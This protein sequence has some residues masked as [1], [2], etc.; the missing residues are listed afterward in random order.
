MR[1][2][3][4]GR[5]VDGSLVD[6]TVSG[7]R[8][9]AVDPAGST[10]GPDDVDLD[11]R[12]LLPALGEPHAHLDK[13]FTADLLPNPRGDLD[14]AVEAILTAWPAISVEDIVGRAERAVRRLVASGT[15][16]IRSHADVT[17]EGE[18]KSV[19]AL[20]EV[21]RRTAHLCH[22][23]VV[24]LTMPLSGLEGGNGR[25]RLSE[26][27]AGGADV[28]G[29]CPHL[30]EE[31][32]A[33]IDAALA[34]AAE[35]GTAADLHFDEVLDASVQHLPDLARQVERRG[36]GGRVTASHCVSH[37][38]LSADRQ[39]HIGRMLADAGV[40]VVTNPRTNL[41][42]QGRG[43]E[44]GP[45]RGLAGVRAL[46]DTG[47]VVAAGADNVQDPFYLIGRSDP[48]ETA[49][50]CVAAAHLTVDE[51]WRLVGDGVRAV[52]GLEPVA[53]AA[54]SPADV[55]AVRAG[56]VREAI[57]D[58]PPD[59]LVFRAGELVAHTRVDAWTA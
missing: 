7:G 12:L 29:A 31:P 43:V 34:A 6:I 21:K 28:V 30:D 40:A 36:L 18:Q 56:S 49:S 37:G 59:R 26:A 24:A 13:A 8:V 42:L 2:L 11:G 52:L 22:L 44:Q 3:R 14:G 38:L 53:V 45:P 15:T 17:P 32:L 51:A 9:V 25:R 47:V 48:L 35:L 1:A 20:A 5:L 55:V 57:A 27:M 46:L 4:A 33:A 16:V 54:G 41:F 19:I 39:R 58:Q 23:E 10:A 50:L